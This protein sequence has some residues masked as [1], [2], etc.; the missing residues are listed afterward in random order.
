MLVA[1]GVVY[2]LHGRWGMALL[3][4]ALL[5]WHV[6]VAQPVDVT[7]L[8]RT[9][10]KEKRARLI[11]LGV[12]VAVFVLLL[13]RCVL[14]VETQRGAR[15]IVTRFA[16]QASGARAAHRGRRAADEAERPAHCDGLRAAGV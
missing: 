1:Q 8:F 11:R 7:E 9:L 10:A 5:A 15:C 12:A 13:V 4:G 3:N 6:R 14:C 2:L 16:A